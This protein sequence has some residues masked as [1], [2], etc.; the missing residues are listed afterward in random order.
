MRENEKA[1]PLPFY[2]CIIADSFERLLKE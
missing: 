1:L 2:Y